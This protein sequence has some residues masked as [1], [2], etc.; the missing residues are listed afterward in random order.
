MPNA[1]DENDQHCPFVNRD[2]GRCAT[3]FHVDSLEPVGRATV[4]IVTS[5]RGRTAADLRTLRPG[6]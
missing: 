2:D 1:F 3:H 4:Q 5:T 6:A